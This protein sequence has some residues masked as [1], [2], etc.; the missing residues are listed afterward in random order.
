MYY[1]PKG[2]A[3]TVDTY[4]DTY[5]DHSKM[6]PGFTMSSATRPI[7][8]GK[9]QEAIRDRGAIIQS[10]RLIEEMKTFIWKNGRP[11]AQS[12][13]NDD[14]VMAF[15]I[16]MYVR[17]TALKYRQRGIDITK[18]ALQNMKVNRTPYQ[19]GY[20]SNSSVPNPYSMQ[21]PDGKEDIRWLLG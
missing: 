9:F 15:G 14:L 16:G 21:T 19:G 12:G 17:D 10:A 18:Q 11:E 8:I 3:L 5:M 6:T 7:S 20:G 2:N 4:F 13:Y 1:S